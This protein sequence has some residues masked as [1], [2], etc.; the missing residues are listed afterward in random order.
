MTDPEQPDLFGGAS[1]SKRRGRPPIGIPQRRRRPGRVERAL[2]PELRD[3]AL[4]E[5]AKVH[6][7]AGAAFVD[8]AEAAG[9]VIAGTKA[10]LGY[11]Q[12]RQSYGLAGAVTTPLD[13]FAAFVAGMATATPSSSSE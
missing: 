8:L 2:V 6:L 4:P 9:D 10:I 7:R 3:S 13:P 12:L 1:K 11:L 5:A